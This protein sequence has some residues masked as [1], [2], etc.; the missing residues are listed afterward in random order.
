MGRFMSPDPLLN[1][2]RPDNPQT[3]APPTPK[4]QQCM[5]DAHDKA[6]DTAAQ[7]AWDNAV[8]PIKETFQGTLIGGVT[9]CIWGIEDGCLPSAAFGATTGALSRII[10]GTATSQYRNLTGY[11]QV[12]NQLKSDLA[13]CTQMSFEPVRLPK[14][15]YA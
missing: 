2:G 9:G 12:R 1:S 11:I 8:L 10:K 15:L 13:A 4:Q 6:N 14:C 7:M 3:P 5:Q